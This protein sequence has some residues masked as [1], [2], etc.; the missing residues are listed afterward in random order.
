MATLCSNGYAIEI[1]NS[2]V[3]SIRKGNGTNLGGVCAFS[4]HRV[5]FTVTHELIV[6]HH[7][8]PHRHKS[9]RI[10]R[11][12]D[13]L[14]PLDVHVAECAFCCRKLSPLFRKIEENIWLLLNGT[15]EDGAFLP[16]GMQPIDSACR[17]RAHNGKWVCKPTASSFKCQT[18]MLSPTG[19]N[20]WH[21]PTAF[22]S[23]CYTPVGVTLC[24]PVRPPQTLPPNLHI[25]WKATPQ[26]SPIF[27][28]MVHTTACPCNRQKKVQPTLSVVCAFST[29]VHCI[30]QV[31]QTS[32]IPEEV[33]KTLRTMM[34]KKVF[35][36]LWIIGDGHSVVLSSVFKRKP[37]FYPH[38]TLMQ[39]Y[40]DNPAVQSLFLVWQSNRMHG[41]CGLCYDL[42]H[43]RNSNWRC[44]SCRMLHRCV[45]ADDNESESLWPWENIDQ[46]E[47][48]F[49]CGAYVHERRAVSLLPSDTRDARGFSKRMV[50][51][52]TRCSF[53][54]EYC[55]RN[56]L[57]TDVTL[58]VNGGMCTACAAS[59]S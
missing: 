43:Y 12:L 59:W 8:K 17:L 22:C 25:L 19:K 33:C 23:N 40:N 50:F 48:C 10:K 14:A 39:S 32:I 34:A 31:N 58:P 41:N 56:D 53:K 16:R 51:V 29:T 6:T 24:H 15:V 44:Q 1:S 49:V 26:G 2:T 46:C 28:K 57:H 27:P 35:H 4:R 36:A 45:P 30:L 11:L 21:L 18:C 9:H 37:P 47:E 55:G 7:G 20:S 13:I 38:G 54:C 52:C 42:P 3:K 5:V